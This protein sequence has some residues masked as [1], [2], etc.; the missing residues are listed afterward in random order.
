[1]RAGLYLTS[2]IPVLIIIGNSCDWCSFNNPAIYSLSWNFN[3]NLKL[4]F[5]PSC[6]RYCQYMLR[7]IFYLSSKKPGYAIALHNRYIWN[8]MVVCHYACADFYV[9][10]ECNIWDIFFRILCSH[11]YGRVQVQYTFDMFL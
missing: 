10:H 5:Q 8:H 1:M 11:E 9:L 6:E 3:Q 4:F 7:F 2:F